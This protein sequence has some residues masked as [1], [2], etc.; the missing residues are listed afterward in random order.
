M[1]RDWLISGH[2]L[3]LVTVLFYSRIP[4]EFSI[5]AFPFFTAGHS[6]PHLPLHWK[7]LS[8]SAELTRLRGPVWFLPDLLYCLAGLTTWTTVLAPA[9]MCYLASQSFPPPLPQGLFLDFS[10]LIP[11][12]RRSTFPGFKYQVHWRLKFIFSN[13]ALLNPGVLK[14][15]YLIF[16]FGHLINISMLACPETTQFC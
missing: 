6:D 12:L 1:T 15:A 4:Q 16:W 11:L 5:W 14:I 3:S 7:C 9:V 8:R 10:T 2:F 13:L